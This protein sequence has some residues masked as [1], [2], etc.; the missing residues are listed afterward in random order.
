MNVFRSSILLLKRSFIRHYGYVHVPKKVPPHLLGP[1][2][3]WRKCYK[4]HPYSE[5]VSPL[6][7]YQ[8]VTKTIKIEGLPEVYSNISPPNETLIDDSMERAREFLINHFHRMTT[9]FRRT[10]LN[11][12]LLHS[13]LIPVWQLGSKFPHIVDSYLTRNPKIECY[14][15]RNTS[16]YV[17]FTNPL[18][19]LY[20]S[21]PLQLFCDPEN[22]TTE[23]SLPS[24]DYHPSH[25]GLFEHRFDQINVFGGC[26]RQSPYPFSHTLFVMDRTSHSPEQTYAHA[27]MQM[28]TQSAAQTIQNGFQLDKDLHFPLSSQAILTDGKRFTFACYQLNTLDLT[29]ESQSTR[30]NYLWV[31][32]SID[33][34]EY[35][36]CDCEVVGL[37]AECIKIVLQFLLNKPLRKRPPHSGFKMAILEKLAREKIRRGQRKQKKSEHI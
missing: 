7:K 18:S 5:I 13:I 35:V 27:L 16:N 37:N 11:D 26:K 6:Q 4:V 29:K 8:W 23:G 36:S 20:S 10:E 9:N 1:G 32:P 30:Y 28:F 14:W 22:D 25:M 3:V 15:R 2:G 24:F 21:S 19:S 17:C 12:G 34:Y 31:G 33:L